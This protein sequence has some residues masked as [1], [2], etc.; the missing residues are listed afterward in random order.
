MN[1]PQK[2]LPHNLDAERA[3]LGSILND[4]QTI[5]TA[6][7]IL[8]PVDFFS[9]KH[10]KIF[11]AMAKLSKTETPVNILSVTDALRRGG[12]LDEAGGIDYLSELE[13]MVPTAQAITHFCQAVKKKSALRRLVEIG[14]NLKLG[15]WNESD[16]PEGLI[17]NAQNKIYNI[18]LDLQNKRQGK[19]VFG[20]G[21]IAK[22]AV[23]AAAEWMEDPE[24]ARGIQT[25]FVRLDSNLSGLK[26]INVISASTG[27]G[28]TAF[29]LNLGVRVGIYQKIPTLYV[30]CE[31]NL[32]ELTIRLQGIL[33][34]IPSEIIKMG[35]Y[36]D[37]HPWRKIPEASQHISDGNLFLTG[38][39][40]KTI[41]TIISLIQKY[42]AQYGI[43]VVILDYLGEIERTKEELS[44]E[45]NDYFLYGEWVQRLKGVCTSLGIKL[46]LLAQLNREG[47][48]E[49]SRKH[50]GGSWKIVQKSDVFLILGVTKKGQHFL[51]IDKNRNGL[52]PVTINL[53][54]DKETQRIAEV[55]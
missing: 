50:I 38:N 4:A 47:E 23:E 45:K 26:D 37:H 27:I 1:A 16:D 18:A 33:S 44:E 46:I 29:A 30:N 10:A 14:D 25:G 54:F 51:R 2:L 22:M 34:G 40:P 15:A 20:P 8:G 6:L 35:R 24:G 21:E 55:E 19:Q 49:P 3:V 13:G 39:Q 32:E 48:K 31:M 36:S 52:A 41:N 7:V 17:E 12:N 43:K 5:Y 53:N 28:K 9:T 11:R 42:K